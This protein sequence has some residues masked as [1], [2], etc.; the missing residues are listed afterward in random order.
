MFTNSEIWEVKKFKKTKN[1]FSN[2]LKKLLPHSVSSWF[3]LPALSWQPQLSGDVCWVTG[4]CVLSS[5]CDGAG[6]VAPE[7]R[8]TGIGAK[9]LNFKSHQPY[10]LNFWQWENC[11]T[12]VSLSFVIFN[13]VVP[14]PTW[15]ILLWEELKKIIGNHNCCAWHMFHS[16]IFAVVTPVTS[17]LF[18]SY[19][20]WCKL[21][22][23]EWSTLDSRC[24]TR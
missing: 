1:L 4:G 5:L 11:L 3:Y 19:P 17:S 13:I 7:L 15:R 12:S 22:A 2:F 16:I 18:S 23:T 14:I 21:S 20:W 10:L 6:G 8:V 9:T 24:I